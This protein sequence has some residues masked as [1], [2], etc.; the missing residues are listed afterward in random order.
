[1]DD[2]DLWDDVPGPSG[3]GDWPERWEWNDEVGKTLTGTL[4]K[5]TPNV[6]TQFGDKAVIEVTDATGKEWSLMLFHANLAAQMKE[7]RPRIGDTIAVRFD[8]VGVA[9]P[10][11]NA[12]N[13][14][15]VEVQR[16]DVQPT[17]SEP[18]A[19]PAPSSIL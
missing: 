12:P 8:G 11:K 7:K 18:A 1:M 4:S 2:S 9:K 19:T 3:D 10:G 15:T 13:L 5:I 17:T 6:K 16:K 14:Y